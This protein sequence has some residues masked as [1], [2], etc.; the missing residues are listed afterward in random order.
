MRTILLLGELGKRF[1]RRHEMDVRSPAE[2]IRALSANFPDFPGFVA[3]ST[4][5][6]VGYRILSGRDDVNLDQL[7]DP[8][9]RRITIAPVIMGAGG[10]R[11]PL[12]SILIGGAIIAAAFFTGG[13]SLVA[14]QG[15]VFGGLLGQV[16]FG[17]GVSLAL[18][19]VAQL[20]SPPPKAE[21][22]Q[23]QDPPSYVF[24]GAVNTQAQGQPVPIG[25][26][27]M[28]VGSAVISAGLTV[29]DIVA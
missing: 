12:T 23:E 21:G 7:H 29:D 10:G 28:I 24:D 17:I 9:A 16:A 2:A 26:G 19:G 20:I 4:E 27:R 1:G 14:G 18:G 11:N 8:A 13:V 22:P 15:L 6:N 5:R 3:K 25:Y